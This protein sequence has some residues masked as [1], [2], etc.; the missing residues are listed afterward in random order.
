MRDLTDVF[1]AHNA[2][3]GS[4]YDVEA[5]RPGRL[6]PPAV[7]YEA[8]ASVIHQRLS[9]LP[10]AYTPGHAAS[11]DWVY[12]TCRIAALIY[13]TAFIMR[14]PFS[15]AAN[16]SHHHHE[17]PDAGSSA[18][19]SAGDDPTTRLTEALYESLGRTDIANL[20]N[21]MTGVLYWVCAVGAAAARMPSTID[22]T[23]QARLQNEAYSVW[24]RRCL[25]MTS[26]RTMIV[27]IFQHPVPMLI[28][29]K[30]L[31][32]VQELIGTGDVRG[33]E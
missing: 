12:E 11:D 24:V 17:P 2:G 22:M 5:E 3:L 29:Q 6:S 30:R 1:I 27:L 23:A 33:P 25:I 19:P 31:L 26:T 28:A 8:K 13:T 9:S 16:L 32:K 4:V 7:E 21:N 20:W 14:V 18:K 10:S 15:V